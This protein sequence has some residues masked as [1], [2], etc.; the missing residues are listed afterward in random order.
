MAKVLGHG[1]AKEGLGQLAAL[2]GERAQD[3]HKEACLVRGHALLQKRHVRSQVCS[4][5]I[6][7]RFMR[8]ANKDGT[9]PN[10]CPFSTSETAVVSLQ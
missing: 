10:S 4:V 6:R 5:I 7:V 2:R 1:A 3:T 9:E 8:V